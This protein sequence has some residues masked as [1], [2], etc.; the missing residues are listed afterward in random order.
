MT[1]HDSCVDIADSLAELAAGAASGPDRARVLRHVAACPKCRQELAELSRIAEDLL[2]LAP[3]REPPAGFE[4][5]VLARF[6]D[7]AD[8]SREAAAA[9]AQPV[10]SRSWRRRAGLV[11]A[12]A[13]SAAVVAAAAGTAVWQATED[14]RTFGQRYRET[15]AVADGTYF[16]A[17]TM[18]NAAG[19]DV[20][21]VFAYQGDPT[22]LM[23]TVEDA[24]SDG[25]YAVTVVTNGG[26]SIDLGECVVVDGACSTGSTIDVDVPDV[27]QVRVEAEGGPSL[28]ARF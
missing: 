4:G 11:G 26:R 23:V 14:D 16:T 21:H 15:L 7:T 8:E 28:V 22:W 2:L 6:A 20:G 5:A 25:P 18:V 24:P 10:R 19:V 27:R 1:E 17:K 13:A 12:I 3:G 9:A